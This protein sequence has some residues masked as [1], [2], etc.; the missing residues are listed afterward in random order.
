MSPGITAIAIAS[1]ALGIGANAAIFTLAKAAMFDALSV[2]HRI[3]CGFFISGRPIRNTA[4]L[5]D[6]YTD[7]QVY[8]CGRFL[9]AYQ[10]HDRDHASAI[11]LHS[12][13]STSLN[14]SPQ[15]SMAMRKLLQ[16]SLFPATSFK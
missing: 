12:S 6:F 13:M 7:K 14:I 9:S 15:Q 4:R 5:G 3:S 2:P 8:R 11:S 16:R 1:L 10:E